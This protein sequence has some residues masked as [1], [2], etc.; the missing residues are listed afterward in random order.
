[1]GQASVGDEVELGRKVTKRRQ[2]RLLEGGG[3]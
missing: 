3:I 2:G 1:M